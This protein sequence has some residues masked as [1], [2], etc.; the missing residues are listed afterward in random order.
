MRKGKHNM[1]N[2]DAKEALNALDDAVKAIREAVKQNAGYA[3][4]E[5]CER[6]DKAYKSLTEAIQANNWNNIPF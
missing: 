3:T 4:C 6:L 5:E 2:T 1:K